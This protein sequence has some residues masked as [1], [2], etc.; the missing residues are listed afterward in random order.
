[1]TARLQLD[2]FQ[3]QRPQE[4]VLDPELELQVLLQ[5]YRTTIRT[6]KI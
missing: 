1:M 6:F 3:Q 2:Q 4:L 5:I